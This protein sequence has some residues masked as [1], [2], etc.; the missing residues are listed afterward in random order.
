MVA[1]VK[2]IPFSASSPNLAA[3]EA[4]ANEACP[5]IRVAPF[6]PMR[7]AYIQTRLEGTKESVLDKTTRV[8]SDRVA[9]V[10]GKC[11]R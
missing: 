7:I 9:R 4:I 2:V 5:L 3:C 8:L 10:G 11:A 1:T 6:E